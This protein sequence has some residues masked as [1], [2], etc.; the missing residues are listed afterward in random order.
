VTRG[1][2]P[3]APRGGGAPADPLASVEASLVASDALEGAAKTRALEAALFALDAVPAPEG[4]ARGRTD[5][6]RAEVLRRLGRTREAGEAHA[7]VVDALLARPEAVERGLR[8]LLDGLCAYE[9]LLEVLPRALAA[10]P[11]RAWEWRAFGAA[12]R[13]RLALEAAAPMSPGELAAVRAEVAARLARRP[14]AHDDE[15]RPVTADAL[16]A[17]GHEPKAA[18]AWLGALGACCCDCEVA[19]VRGPR[20]PRG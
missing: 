7:R 13:E 16:A 3:A 9:A 6:Y 19:S 18:L 20:E 10:H 17:L 14:C 15:R 2:G 11:G 12:A 1:S 5:A 4:E 8:D